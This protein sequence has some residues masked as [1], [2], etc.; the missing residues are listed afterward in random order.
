M[1]LFDKVDGRAFSPGDAEL[2]RLIAANFST[3]VRLFRAR[4]QRE[5]EERLS[6]IGSLLSSL[7]HDLKSPM[8]VIGG[9]VQMMATTE[10]ATQR[11]AYGDLV[12][13]QFD[14][15]AAMQREVLEFA[16]GE[17]HVLLRKVYLADFFEELAADL[18][19]ELSGSR[20]ELLLE[21]KDRTTARFD[22]NKIGRA[23]HNL[24]RNAVEAMGTRGGTITLRVARLTS[25]RTRNAKKRGDLIIEVTDTGPG[26]PK[27]I[28]GRLF[29]SFATSK[30][31][32]TGLGLAIVHKIV[33]EHGGT[34]SARSTPAGTTFT[35]V[36]PQ[37]D[38]RH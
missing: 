36:L 12:L 32:G 37:D 28:E 6:S 27:E 35:V 15:I 21:L 24:V 14:N 5:R 1:A 38:L 23:L 4:A 30:K 2:L 13:K 7:I 25:E 34:V 3:A 9:Y 31:G 26:I 10:D 18:R 8:A 19:R 33:S 29:Q 17:K 11:K 20:A 16:R 22:Q